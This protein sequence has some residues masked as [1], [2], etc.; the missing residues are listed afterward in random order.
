[1]EVMP[2]SQP[3]LLLVDDEVAVRRIAARVLQRAG[4][5]CLEA[6][7][8]QEAFRLWQ[9]ERDAIALVITDVMMPRQNGWEL[10]MA[11]RGAGSNCPFVVTSGIDA[12]EVVPP[13]ADEGVLVL[14]KPW[15]AA[16]LVAAVKQMLG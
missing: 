2:S 7:D 12:N 13:G 14:Q 9:E 4:F 1:L 3:L 16:Q 15:E 11:V 6:E 10:L 8:G 5:R